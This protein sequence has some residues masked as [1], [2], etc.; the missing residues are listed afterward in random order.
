MRQILTAPWASASMIIR[1]VKASTRSREVKYIPVKRIETRVPTPQS[2][3]RT[4][5]RKPTEP[6]GG[7]S[8]SRA[9]GSPCLRDRLVVHR[10]IISSAASVS[11]SHSLPV[12]VNAL[13][14]VST[15]TGR[16]KVSQRE[17]GFAFC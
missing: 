10:P 4:Q 12:T 16:T 2:C 13:H 5:S 1:G 7:T 14:R 17:R 6:N 8:E 9:V 15:G 3:D 11:G